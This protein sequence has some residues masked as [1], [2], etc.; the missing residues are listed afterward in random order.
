[1]GFFRKFS[2]FRR[3]VPL[4][5]TQL[6]FLDPT[7]RRKGVLWFH[8]YQ[9]V[10]MSVVEPVFAKTAHRIFLR[11][12]KNLGCLKGKNWRSRISGKKSH[13]EDNTKNIPKMSFFLD[14]ATTKKVHWPL[15]CRFYG[16]K[17]CTIMMFMILLKTHVWQKYGSRVRCKNPLG[18]PDCRIFKL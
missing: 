9:Y 17:S 5:L 3:S 13:F 6:L 12:L 18:Q 16:L 7:F 4:N 1:M 14:F 8:H 2:M 15:V 10:S 11:F